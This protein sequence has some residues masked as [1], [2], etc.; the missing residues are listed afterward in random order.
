MDQSL[1]GYKTTGPVSGG[2]HTYIRPTDQSLADY[3]TCGPVSFRVADTRTSLFRVAD[4]RTT[5]NSEV[6]VMGT[7]LYSG[8]ADMRTFLLRSS[9]HAD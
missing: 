5:L 6:A 3:K 7:N 9:R 2:L 8:V 1:L 4:T